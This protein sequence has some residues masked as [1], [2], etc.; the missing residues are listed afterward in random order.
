MGYDG[1]SRQGTDQ[2]L[3]PVWDAVEHTVGKMPIP[4]PSEVSIL[5]TFPLFVVSEVVFSSYPGFS[6]S[7]VGRTATSHLFVP[8]DFVNR[9][10]WF[11]SQGRAH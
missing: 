1:R 10:D 11:L 4:D 6:T 9:E 7:E 2:G 3:E 8:F 5:T